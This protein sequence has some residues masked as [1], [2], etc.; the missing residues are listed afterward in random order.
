M[1]PSITTSCSITT[2]YSFVLRHLRSLTFGFELYSYKSVQRVF[3]LKQILDTSPNLSHLVVPW[4]DFRLCTRAYSNLKYIH[5]ILRRLHPEP[6]QHVN[7]HRLSQLA[8]NLCRLATSHANIM[9][10]E[11]LVKFVLKIIRRFPKL[12]YLTLNKDSLYPS[13]EEKKIIFKERLMT[14]AHG[15]LFKDSNI[16]IKL[17]PLCDEI[18]IWF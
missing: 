18:R 7:V 3:L 1:S 12:V 2:N 6:K 9:F 4:T 14:D 8:P 5:L 13:K 17:F 11:N 15:H 16:Q 10:N